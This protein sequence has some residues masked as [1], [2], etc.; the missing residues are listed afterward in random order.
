[1]MNRVRNADSVALAGAVIGVP[2]VFLGWWTFK[3]NRI[4]SGTAVGVHDVYGWGLPLLLLALWVTCL[5]LGVMRRDRVAAIV[6]GLAANAVLVLAV[7]LSGLAATRLLAGEPAAS[8]VSLGLGFWLTLAACYVVIFAARQRLKDR[9][10]WFHGLSWGGALFCVVWLFTGR[11][12]SLSVLMEYAGRSD[13]FLQEFAHHVVLVAVS[14][15]VGAVLGVAL[16]FWAVRSRQA[17]RPIFFVAN[18]TQTIP[19]LALFGILI[20]PLSALSFSYPWLRDIGVRGV[21]DAPAILALVIYSL[22]PIVR[23]TYT[24]LKNVDPAIVNAG[25][26]MGMSRWQLLR[27]IETPLAAPLILEGVRT[28]SVQSV[29]LT[30]V[31]ALIGAGGLGWF[32]FQGLG[33]AAS[34]LIILGTIPILFLALVVDGAMRLAVRVATPKGL[35]GRP[36]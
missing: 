31:A 28:A 13:R 32:I 24:G 8:R 25:A 33:Q 21:G 1:M 9:P 6:T 11:L 10:A 5:A 17:E 18:I 22:L 16:G 27:R 14:V 36:A 2:S 7:A 34:D 4:V 3:A 20:A 19:S 15:S 29:G 26:G 30:A 12:D 35:A 23:N